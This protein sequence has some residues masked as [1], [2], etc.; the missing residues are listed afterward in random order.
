MRT[1]SFYSLS[2][3]LQDR[4]TGSISEGFPPRPL[5]VVPGGP[6]SERVW[7]G[8]MGG[9]LLGVLVLYLVGY[10]S[11]GSG[12]SRHGP[13]ALGLY[14]GFIATAV[15][16]FVK[17]RRHLTEVKSLPIPRGI[18]LFPA[19]VIDATSADLVVFATTEGQ[20]T[21]TAGGVSL[22][23]PGK[24]FAF[25]QASGTQASGNLAEQLVVAQRETAEAVAQNDSAKLST[26][27]PLHEPRFSSPVGPRAPYKFS[28][29][30]WQKLGWAIA[31]GV[32]LAFGLSLFFMR[33]A[34]SD[35]LLYS[36]AKKADTEEAYRAYLVHGK[37]HVREV[38]LTLLPRA[39]LKAASAKGSVEAVRAFRADFPKTDIED[40]YAEALR[41]AMTAELGRAKA[42]GKLGALRAFEKKYPD[43]GLGKDLAAAVH[44]V[45]TKE[46]ARVIAASP[47][48]ERAEIE[49]LYTQ[50]F[51]ALEKL[52]PTV[53][54]RFRRKP[55]PKLTS[56]DKAIVKTA[57]W[58]G[59]VSYVSKY[60]D[61]AHHK[62]R[63]D[64][65]AKELT[66][67][68][69]PLFD[70]ELVTIV[71]SA[72]EPDTGKGDEPFPKVKVPTLFFVHGADWSGHTYTSRKP[73]VTM[74]GLNFSFDAVFV[75]PED[76]R[77]YKTKLDL[78]KGIT[79]PQLREP[80]EGPLEE[81][82]YE[83]MAKSAY[84]AFEKKLLDAFVVSGG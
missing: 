57:T 75:L 10:G 74:V 1:V 48:A 3:V 40:E 67:K 71:P 11:L 33:N 55:A 31:L 49:P 50:L 66:E 36:R 18:Y 42:T 52:G 60:F 23:F 12:L 4:L 78:W 34:T 64:V 58:N 21:G 46:L 53:E 27:D 39:A 28:L 59:V 5:A 13:V 19:C 26:L 72:A 20:A 47:P 8:V 61:A 6:R 22:A 65:V 43:H 29:P 16:G 73:H 45:Y 81:R 84:G 69:V 76:K 37:T 9:G 83:G 77:A 32:G 80:G 41:A 63:E 7:L 24:T 79:V 82:L 38:E 2:R 62:V 30:A 25:T 56:A 17:S 15:F 68:L 70:P 44:E 14:V 54:I 51:A 35:A